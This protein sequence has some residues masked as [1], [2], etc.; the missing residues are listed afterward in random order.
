MKKTFD[1]VLFSTFASIILLLALIP[2]IGYIT[3]IPGIASVT[4]IHIPVLIGIMFLPLYYSLGLGFVFGLSSF[5]ASF[6]YAKEPIDFAFQNP[7]I[8]IIPRILF[9]LFAYF[10]IKGLTKLKDLKNGVIINYIIVFLTT[11]L[12]ITFGSYNLI[13]ITGWSST[14]I[15][16]IGFLLIVGLLF[17]SFN[18]INK[19]GANISYVPTS[20]ITSTFIHSILVLTFVALIKIDAYEGANVLKVI[21]IVLGTNGLVEAI[22]ALF[23]GTPIVVA[24]HH[25]TEERR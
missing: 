22:L 1:L 24:L 12:F 15:Y 23:I 9:A 11:S 20:I 5:I 16:I 18:Y 8:S 17:L 2:N 14:I 4:I 10:I 25:L 21:L 19:K 6:I 3:I 7:I 13:N